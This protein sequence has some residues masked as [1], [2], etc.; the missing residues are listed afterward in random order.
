MKLVKPGSPAIRM[1][2]KHL[3]KPGVYKDP[4]NGYVA[5]SRKRFAIQNPDLPKN[6]M[7]L[8][9]K[10]D[11]E[12]GNK[13]M[14]QIEVWATHGTGNLS[15]ISTIDP[16]KCQSVQEVRTLVQVSAGACAEHLCEAFGDDLDPDYCAKISL[17]LLDEL[18]MKNKDKFQ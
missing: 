18:I 13:V 4:N 1:G 12:T 2:T 6:K 7:T 16:G 8:S 14:I 9:L 17:E 15:V 11:E 5:M 3:G 10:P